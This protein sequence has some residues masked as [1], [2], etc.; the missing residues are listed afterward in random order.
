M[1]ISDLEIL[2][3]NEEDDLLEENEIEETDEIIETDEIDEV[4]EAD[5][6]VLDWKKELISWIFT[7]ALTVAVVFVLKNYII[8]NA[9]VPTGSMEN[10]IM[11]GDNLMGYRL[12]YLNDEPK[13]GDVIFFYFPDDESQK[14]VKRIIGLPGETVYIYDGAI[15]IDDATSPLRETYLKEEWTVGTGPYVFE[16]PEDSYLVL[17]DNRNSSQDA[18]YWMNP[19]VTKEKIIGKAIFTYFPFSRWGMVQ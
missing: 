16:V 13:R 9:S 2:D 5:E 12:A 7:I 6:E 14:Y 3:L 1:K 18:R 17:G 10:T 19:Y 4:E 11:P 8:I 15:Y